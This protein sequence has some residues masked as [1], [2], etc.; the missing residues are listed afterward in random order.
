MD[1]KDLEKRFMHHP[2]KDMG[3]VENHQAVRN[4]CLDLASM[5]NQIVPEGREKALVI[6]HLEEVMFW[7]N[8]GIA[9]NG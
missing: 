2:P 8:A 1:I 9:R 3:T 6:T 7:A 4:W 5:L